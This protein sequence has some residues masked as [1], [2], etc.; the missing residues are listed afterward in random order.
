MV[1]P[2]TVDHSLGDELED[3][4]VRA[5]EHGRVLDP[6]ADEVVD[7]EEAPVVATPAVAAP[8]HQLEVLLLEQRGNRRAEIR[9]GRE[10]EAPVTEHE[11]RPVGTDGVDHEIAAVDEL[12][13]R[14]AEQREHDAAAG[15]VPVDVEHLGVLRGAAV[16]QH[17][18]PPRSPG[19]HVI[20]HDVE[21][22]P[23]RV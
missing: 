3:Q 8:L 15:A 9:F 10:R 23:E 17:V 21:H 22:E 20:G 1:D 4:R 14:R 16:T 13:D 12:A 5:G 6:D 7:V 2:D 11:G 18:V 19:R